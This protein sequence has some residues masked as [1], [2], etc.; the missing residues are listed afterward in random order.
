MANEVT[1]LKTGVPAEL[2]DLLGDSDDLTANVSAGFS[3]VSFRGGKWRV[4]HD[5][6]ETLITDAEGEPVASLKVV[7]VK[8]N[9]H[10]SKNYYAKKFE[11][12]ADDAPVCFSINGD[13]PDPSSP[14]PQNS[15]CATCPKNA[16]GS[17]ITD[18]GK[19][20][21]ACADHRRVA[22]IPEGDFANE[23]LGGPMLLRVPPTSLKDLAKYGRGFRG[24]PHAYNTVVTRVS[25]DTETSYPRPVFRAER[26]LTSDEASELRGLLLGDDEFKHKLD[27][28]LNSFSDDV[29]PTEDAAV[30]Q[31]L[32][33]QDEK[34]EEPK[35]KKTRAK[36]KPKAEPEPEPEE[37]KV[38][39][40]GEDD[41]EIQN[42]LDELEM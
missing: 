4:K 7:M 14:E 20:A 15:N 10:V 41:D 28:I 8:A 40:A 30:Q 31:P 6:E 39:V 13:V 12:G 25:L 26:P 5:G 11:E 1:T 32:F 16:F 21:K 36:R 27:S 35:P 29:V 22:V 3:V 23:R 2:K 17:R 9:P 24:T 38:E 37:E 42:L 18:E 19:K 34:E 33:A